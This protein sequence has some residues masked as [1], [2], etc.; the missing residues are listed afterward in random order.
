MKLE[1]NSPAMHASKLGFRKLKKYNHPY[2]NST[3]S[4]CKRLL[5]WLRNGEQL[6]TYQIRARGVMHAAGRIQN[7][8]QQGYKILTHRVWEND[9]NDVPHYFA[10]YVLIS[11]KGANAKREKF[12]V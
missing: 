9:S 4:Q 7:L 12:Y 3:A 2:D 1:K 5:E 11:E 8:K 6:S 10:K